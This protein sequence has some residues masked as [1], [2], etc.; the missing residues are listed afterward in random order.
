MKEKKNRKGIIAGGNWI[1]DHIKLIEVYPSEERLATILQEITSNGGAPYNLL[2]TL[3]KMHTEIP[4]EGIGVIGD[5]ANGRLIIAECQSMS[6]NSD[7]IKKIENTAT[8][9]TDVMT[10]KSTGRR[11]FFHYRGANALLGKEHFDFSQTR[12]KVFHLGYLLLLDGL[13][14]IDQNG[15]T[16]AAEILKKAKSHDLLTSIDIVSE[17]SN[18]YRE[19][20]P[21]SLPYVDFLFLNEFEAGMLTG[22]S[23][24]DEQGELIVEKG[25]Q[26][27]D[28]LLDLGVLQWVIIHFRK[29]AIAASKSGDK[30]YQKGV[31]FPPED[32]KGTVG[33]GDAFAAGVLAGLHEN[34]SMKRS[35]VSGVSVAASSLRDVT[36]TGSIGSWEDC[37]DLGNTYGWYP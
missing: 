23:V 9:Y 20:I 37:M 30:L 6:I 32:I 28:F 22:V 5:D 29:G 24:L 25:F 31:R 1:V 19:I 34:W 10:V 8:S 33:A 13:D 11:T 26:A 14:V 21:P 4:L 27:A 36:S 17:Q 2:V 7:Q 15:Q 16:D 18:R 12:A 35:L 3:Y